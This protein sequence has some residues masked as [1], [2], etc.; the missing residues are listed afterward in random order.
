VFNMSKTVVERM[1]SSWGIPSWP[2]AV[3]PGTP[4][5]GRYICREFKDELIDAGALTRVGRD[6]VVIGVGYAAWLAKKSAGVRG[7]QIAP[8]RK[9]AE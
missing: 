5:K 8:N 3:Y 4:A 7:F 9:P 2:A 6:L 1:P